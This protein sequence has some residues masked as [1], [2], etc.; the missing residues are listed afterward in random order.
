M[1]VKIISNHISIFRSTKW[2]V[3]ARKWDN[4]NIKM[5]GDIKIKTKKKTKMIEMMT[6]EIVVIIVRGHEEKNRND[7]DDDMEIADIIGRRHMTKNEEK[8]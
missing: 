5:F 4:E 6:L 3:Q 1:L 8:T 7:K 2:E